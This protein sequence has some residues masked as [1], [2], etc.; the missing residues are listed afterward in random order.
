MVPEAVT[1]IPKE[2]HVLVEWVA[3]SRPF[4]KRSQEFYRTIAAMVFLFAIILFF[5][6]EI[7]LIMVILAVCFVAYA[8]YTVPPELIKNKITTLGIQTDEYF[9]KWEEMYEFWFDEKFGQK[10]LVVRL[11]MGFP[12][13]LQL[14]LGNQNPVEIKKILADKL[15][16]REKPERTFLDNAASWLSSKIPLERAS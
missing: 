12:T 9:H 1:T 10:M 15:P 5:V 6:R 13:H 7:L 2:E 16:Y 3:P 8:L 11:L 14:L 4:K